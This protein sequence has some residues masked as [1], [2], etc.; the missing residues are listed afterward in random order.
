VQRH[1]QFLTAWTE[2]TPGRRRGQ[3]LSRGSLVL[4]KA[5]G[6]PGFLAAELPMAALQAAD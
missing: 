3:S 1:E 4:E 6:A 2:L 5:H